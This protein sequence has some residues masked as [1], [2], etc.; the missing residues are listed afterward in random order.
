MH[1]NPPDDPRP[2]A[3]PIRPIPDEQAVP[4]PH[5]Y[6]APPRR[7]GWGTLFMAG[8]ALIFGIAFFQTMIGG[9]SSN[10]GALVVACQDVVK[11]NLK[12]PG[13][14]KFIGV[15][16]VSGKVISGQVDS[17]NSFGATLRSSFQCTVINQETVRL[18]FLR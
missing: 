17:E 7:P 12:A 14:A 18:D 2:A 11:K 10:D 1:T 13:T 3:R 6:Q 15:P 8:I 9:S 4:T 5:V 16:K